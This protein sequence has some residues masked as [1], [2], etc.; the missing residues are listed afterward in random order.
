MRICIERF[1]RIGTG[2]GRRK[3][4]PAPICLPGQR[5]RRR[6]ACSHADPERFAAGELREKPI[7][8]ETASSPKRF[9]VQRHGIDVQR[10]GEKVFETVVSSGNETGGRRFPDPGQVVQVPVAGEA[11]MKLQI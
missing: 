4:N 5:V 10:A 11:L 6:Y 1:D 2:G 9:R 3:H 7:K 8:R